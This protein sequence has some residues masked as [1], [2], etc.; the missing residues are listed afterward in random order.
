MW[1]AA[2]GPESVGADSLRG[3]RHLQ[4]SGNGGQGGGWGQQQQQQQST[5]VLEETANGQVVVRAPP[6][7]P[8]PRSL[9]G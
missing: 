8:G 5:I 2:P 7:Q 4:G 6:A 1:S 9:L 3:G